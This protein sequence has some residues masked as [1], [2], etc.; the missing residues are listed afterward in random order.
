MTLPNPYTPGQVPRYLAGR[1]R[2]RDLLRD[3]M[4][5]VATFGEFGGSV[6]AVH[7]PRGLGKT[8]LLRV[9]QAEAEEA[10]FVTAWVS[11][12]RGGPLL[13]EL[14]F[15]VDR[16]LDRFDA[17]RSDRSRRRLRDR[18]TKLGL[19]VGLPGA[20]VAAEVDLREA[21]ASVSPAP[22]GSLLDYLHEASVLVRAAG[23]AGLLVFIDEIHA[24]P[25]GE[26]GVLLNVLQNMDGERA[27][28]P[29]AVV[30]AG[31]PSTPEAL[32]RAAT[33]GERST[34][35]ELERLDVADSRAVLTEPARAL[36]VT[37]SSQA[38]DAVVADTAGYPYFLQ[39]LGA[40]AW[41]RLSPDAGVVIGVDDL[42]AGYPGAAGQLAAMF[43][44]RW[45]AATAAEQ[46]L[47]VAMAA[48]G[49]D[50]VPRA[51]IAEAVGKDSRAIGVPRNR[52]IEKG[53][54]E[55]AGHGLLRF[56]I[57][58]FASYIRAQ[59]DLSTDQDLARPAHP[60]L[61]WLLAP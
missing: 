61:G 53:I 27:H 40:A 49:V 4:G 30:V 18:V 45:N 9:T 23:S 56:T 35:V 5:R 34:F 8:S 11:V 58:G 43:A 16:A 32:T 15:A 22:T 44:A 2:E 31:L 25:R 21:R 28:H 57:P 14:V 50:S 10:G 24:A 13:A 7:A 20:K 1:R 29:L 60:E 17:L 46:D 59:N 33:F 19:E 47:L 42:R 3:R 37:W 36:G 55:P 26:L 48:A 51:R 54:I 38:L 52:L 6:V 12:T 39:L 41:D